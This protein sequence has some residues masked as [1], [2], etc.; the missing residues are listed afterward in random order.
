MGRAGNAAGLKRVGKKLLGPSAGVYVD[1][2]SKKAA[3]EAG[4]ELVKFTIDDIKQL[5][6]DFVNAA[7]LAIDVAGFDFV[8]INAGHG[9]VFAQFLDPEMNFRSDRYGGSIENR[10]RLLLEVVDE[11]SAVIGAHKVGIRL[12]PYTVFNGCSGAA[13]EVMHP[14]AKYSYL[15][16][17]LERRGKDNPSDRI[18]FIHQVEARVASGD[19]NGDP[20]YNSE[21]V[22]Q[23]WKGILIRTGGYLHQADYKNLK[24]AIEEWF[25]VDTL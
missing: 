18:A 25:K 4:N 9:F 23:I 17:E 6:L 21:W 2:D 3:I 1:E 13:S 19:E 20:G 11:L 15:Y 14:I 22:N 16:S 10:T 8:E 7:K 12:S 24:E 5:K